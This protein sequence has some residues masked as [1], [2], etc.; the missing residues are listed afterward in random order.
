M[1]VR[2]FWS[3]R[4]DSRPHGRA[5]V[6][7]TYLPYLKVP[8]TPTLGQLDL[9][10]PVGLTRVGAP[11]LLR[12]LA[13][14]CQAAIS[15]FSLARPRPSPELSQEGRLRQLDAKQQ[16][17]IHELQSLIIGKHGKVRTEQVNNTIDGHQQRQF[18][19][20]SS[21]QS[22]QATNGV[23]WNWALRLLGCQ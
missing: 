17:F 21:G 12:A 1:S 6:P 8:T 3:A 16:G 2:G 23:E 19:P 9:I 11:W 20:P 4:S 5:K 15:Y 13:P 18:V 14:G 22:H 7:T 10:L